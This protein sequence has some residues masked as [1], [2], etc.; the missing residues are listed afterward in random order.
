MNIC[1]T[2]EVFDEN[3]FDEDI[4]GGFLPSP[5]TLQFPILT[6]LASGCRIFE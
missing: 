5:K 2:Y 4:F 3:F 1:I 6:D